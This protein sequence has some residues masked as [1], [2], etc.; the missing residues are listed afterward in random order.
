V[1]LQAAINRSITE[2]N[3]DPRPFV[4]TK[5]AKAILAPET[6]LA[7]PDYSAHR[8]GAGHEWSTV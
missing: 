4:W 8:R 6:C 3:N 2:H 1:D 5:P 7:G